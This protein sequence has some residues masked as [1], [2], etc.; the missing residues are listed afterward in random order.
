MIEPELKYY[1]VRTEIETILSGLEEG[2]AVPS[3]R[4]LAA[5]FTVARETV[6]QALRDL[7]VEGRI[8]R[9]GR[10]MG[11]ERCSAAGHSPGQLRIVTHRAMEHDHASGS[12]IL[13]GE[14]FLELLLGPIKPLI[15]RLEW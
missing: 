3:E 1:R 14:H 9:R 7:L 13:P 4:E 11:T 2:D 6:R 8:E 15:A 5:R 10:G 12:E